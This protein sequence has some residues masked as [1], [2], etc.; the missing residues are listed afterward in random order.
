MA[1]EDGRHGAIA[2]I[3]EQIEESRE[4]AEHFQHTL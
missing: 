3:D 2:E 4:H 1:I